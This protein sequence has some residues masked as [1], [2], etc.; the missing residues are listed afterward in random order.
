MTA[1]A[2]LMGALVA[3][4]TIREI[5][6]R[7]RQLRESMEEARRER[8]FS[9]Q[10]LEGMVSAVAAVDSHDRIRSA[11]PAFFQIFPDAKV[12][13]SVHSQ[14]SSPGA[15]KMLEAATSSRVE[16]ATYRGRWDCDEN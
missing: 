13:V 10:M 8:E 1:I 14:L 5:Q 2:L 11:N 9:A 6:R 15:M 12:G 16:R 4:Y 7:F 3:A